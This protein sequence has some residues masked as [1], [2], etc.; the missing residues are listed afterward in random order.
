MP[1]ERG[2]EVGLTKREK[3]KKKRE[4]EATEWRGGKK[5][6]KA[7]LGERAMEGDLL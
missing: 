4:K 1:G 2:N 7:V 3:E 5:C 6:A